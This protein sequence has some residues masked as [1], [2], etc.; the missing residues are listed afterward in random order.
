MTEPQRLIGTRRRRA[1][2][3]LT[4]AVAANVALVI[5]HIALVRRLHSA[6]APTNLSTLAW[7]VGAC[8][9]VGVVV[10]WT[11]L[12]RIAGVFLMALLAVGLVVGGNEH[13]IVRGPFNIFTQV[14]G[15]SAAQFVASCVL[16]AAVELV[17]I[18]FSVRVAT[19]RA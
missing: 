13:F 7:I 2:V 10:L 19:T 16:L 11:P 12:S 18:W 14:A 5:W 15:G 17:G 1:S 4:L 6:D 8:S 9:L 3:I